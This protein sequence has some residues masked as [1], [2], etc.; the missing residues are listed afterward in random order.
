VAES[1]IVLGGQ[2]LASASR[3]AA[4]RR[5][6]DV[7]FRRRLDELGS[8]TGLRSS[9]GHR[10]PLTPYRSG[11]A[12][13]LI[14]P[15][16]RAG[17]MPA[18]ASSIGPTGEAC[19]TVHSGGTEIVTITTLHLGHRGSPVGPVRSAL[20]SDPTMGARTFRA[21]CMPACPGRVRGQGRPVAE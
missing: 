8:I 19:R 10:P 14:H 12:D 13:L 7:R 11:A 5:H 4:G 6:G 1:R 3:D 18:G 15:G 20:P 16:A 2:D 17:S 21:P 9:L